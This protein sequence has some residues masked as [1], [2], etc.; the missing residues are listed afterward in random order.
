MQ[1]NTSEFREQLHKKSLKITASRLSIY[2]VLV[3]AKGPLTIQEITK[4]IPDIHFV[5][6]Y[7]SVDALFKAGL[8]K[9]VPRGF[10]NHFELSDDFKPHHHH[11]T[12]EICGKSREVEDSVVEKMLQQLTKRAGLEPTKH[13]FELFGICQQCRKSR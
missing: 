10:K 12:C 4:Q 8:I 3:A 13:H 9:Q 1:I 2:K 5:S 7:R 11:A 6:V